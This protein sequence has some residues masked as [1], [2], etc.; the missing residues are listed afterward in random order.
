M[1]IYFWGTYNHYQAFFWEKVE[2]NLKE[3]LL[4]TDICKYYIFYINLLYCYEMH[5]EIAE[6]EPKMKKYIYVM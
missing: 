6:M 3:H 1:G 5:I 4:R 2:E